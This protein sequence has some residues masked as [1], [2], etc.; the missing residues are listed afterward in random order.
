MDDNCNFAI[1]VVWFDVTFEAFVVVFLLWVVA[2]VLKYPR[3]YSH[4]GMMMR[5]R[6]VP[7]KFQRLL[8]R[9]V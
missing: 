1:V 7:W 5:R 8:F 4:L 3:H 6:M 2:M 9:F